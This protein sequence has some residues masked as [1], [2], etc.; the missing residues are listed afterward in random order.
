MDGKSAVVV[1]LCSEKSRD[2][3]PLGDM[4]ELLSL[5][6]TETNFVRIEEACFDQVSS[7]LKQSGEAR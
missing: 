6:Y 4:F 1:Y 7:I 5:K 3:K 2:F